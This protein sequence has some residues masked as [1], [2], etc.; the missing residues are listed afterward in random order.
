MALLLLVIISLVAREA[1]VTIPLI[2]FILS[3]L[4][5]STVAT[6]LLHAPLP[7]AL[8]ILLQHLAIGT[9]SNTLPD[10]LLMPALLQAPP[11]LRT[12]QALGGVTVAAAN[13]NRVGPEAKL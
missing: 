12:V 1:A 4:A 3:T 11:V 7:V 9:A 8:D 2:L 6:A 10:V 13:V 5:L